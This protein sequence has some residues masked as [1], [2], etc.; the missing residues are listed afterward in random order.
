LVTW[1][2]SLPCRAW[3]PHCRR[4]SGQGDDVHVAFGDD[5]GVGFA[6][7]LAGLRQAEQLAPFFEERRLRRVQVFRLA[8]VDDAAAE[9]D[10]L[11]LGVDDRDHQAVAETVVAAAGLVLD[12]Q[13]GIFSS[14]AL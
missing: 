14:S 10:D 4:R 5:G 3:Q 2:A 8:L 11:A 1:V 13:A 7:G 9:G 6:Q 12:D